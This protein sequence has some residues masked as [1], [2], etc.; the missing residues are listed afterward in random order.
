MSAWS[1]AAGAAVASGLAVLLA[2]PSG[3]ALLGRVRPR[4]DARRTGRRVGPGGTLG[5]RLPGARARRA[6]TGRAVVIE[7]TLALAAASRAGLA[8]T[9]V[10]EEASV[11]ARERDPGGDL[12]RSLPGAP[13]AGL[14]VG[15]VLRT[16]AVAPG[17]GGLHQV[18]ACW[19]ACGGAGAGLATALE[20][21]ADGLRQD[22]A[23]RRQVV[24]ELAAPRSTAR[25]LAVLPVAGVVLGTTAGADPLG[26]LLGTAV[27]RGC[28]LLGLGLAVA[29]LL[30]VERI[31][32]AAR[33][34]V[35]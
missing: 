34:P 12:L 13:A 7:A 31:A 3:A 9:A 10:L 14:E 21:V 23:L 5:L 35:G 25:L 26:V 8:P 1:G 22:E 29:G 30:W 11:A 19:Q 16:A 15:E 24:A 28:L 18:A 2:R 32:H 33:P 6:V 20:R 4:A 27:G 17:A